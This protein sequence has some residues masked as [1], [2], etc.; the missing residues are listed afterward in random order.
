V[1]HSTSLNDLILLTTLL[2][3]L[4][5][6]LTCWIWPFRACRHCGGTGRIQSPFLRAI[7]LCPSCEATGLRLRFGRRIW[8]AYRSLQDPHHHNRH[9]H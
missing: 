3:T 8:N 9:K 4:G 2:F 7:R 5:Y 6:I 1:T